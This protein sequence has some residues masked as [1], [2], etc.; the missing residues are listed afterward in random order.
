MLIYKK[1]C[2][3]SD[4]LFFFYLQ[5]VKKQFMCIYSGN[6]FYDSFVIVFT[7]YKLCHCKVMESNV[8]LIL[9]FNRK[10]VESIILDHYTYFFKI[11]L[12]IEHINNSRCTQKQIDLFVNI[13]SCLE[14]CQAYFK[15]TYMQFQHVE[16]VLKITFI[17]I[18][19]RQKTLKFSRCFTP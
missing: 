13:Y 12:R 2:Q 19:S 1:I 5:F 8:Y 11:K 14:I 16:K 18:F 10:K 6:T 17:E 7:L 4:F 3:N 9:K 15:G